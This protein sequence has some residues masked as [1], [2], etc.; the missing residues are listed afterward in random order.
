M[1]IDNKISFLKDCS[2]NLY[3][4]DGVVLLVILKLK[5]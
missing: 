3:S 5:T 2:S 1:I 4:K